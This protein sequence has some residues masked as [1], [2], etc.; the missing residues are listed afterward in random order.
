MNKNKLLT[1]SLKQMLSETF[2]TKVKVEFIKLS[3]NYNFHVSI[4]G[5]SSFCRIY[6]KDKWD[7]SQIEAEHDY[8]IFAKSAGLTV[9]VPK[10][11]PGGCTIFELPDSALFAALFDWCPGH[12]RPSSKWDEKFVYS[13]GQS[14][15]DLHSVSKLYSSGHIDNNRPTHMDIPWHRELRNLLSESNLSQELRETLLT[16]IGRVES[17]LSGLE[18]T[19]DV[20]GLVHY[21]FHPGNI[22]VDGDD[23]WIIDLDDI[24]HHWYVWDFA[25]PR[26]RLAGKAL[27]RNNEH[28]QNIFLSGYK[29]RTELQPAWESRLRLFERFRHVYMLGWLAR[30]AH[31]PK[32]GSIFPRYAAGHGRYIKEHPCLEEELQ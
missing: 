15:G 28:L 11:L 1:S 3:S 21:D 12:H 20:Y 24:C 27:S 10:E 7:K 6:E 22:L 31:N 26:H 25:M 17:Y 16:E 8:L 19:S 2:R 29:S 32:W 9:Q 13:W 23:F 4:D 14:L 5:C 30:K 18:Q